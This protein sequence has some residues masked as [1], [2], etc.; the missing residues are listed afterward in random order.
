[1]GVVPHEF[2]TGQPRP[3][4]LLR[5]WVRTV[6]HKKIGLL[7]MLMAVVFLVLGGAEALAKFS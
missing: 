2:E 1:M 7:Y 5:D 4:D 6:D 3:A